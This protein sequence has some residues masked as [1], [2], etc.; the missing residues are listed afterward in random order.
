[1]E[2]EWLQWVKEEHIPEVMDTGKFTGYYLF[3][4]VASGSEQD[5]K[6]TSYSVQF[7]A[8]SM[9]ELQL[10]AATHAPELQQ[11]MKQR[12]SDKLATFKTVLESIGGFI[13]LGKSLG[14]LE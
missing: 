7:Y 2:E 14:H 3:R 10:Y 5:E 6:S 13:P 9:K 4:V 1:M 12:W 11:K 8:E